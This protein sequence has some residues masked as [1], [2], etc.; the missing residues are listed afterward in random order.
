MDNEEEQ[1]S[2]ALIPID[3]RNMKK[4][5]ERRLEILHY[6]REVVD[7]LYAWAQTPRVIAAPTNLIPSEPIAEPT[8]PALDASIEERIIYHQ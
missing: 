4:D 6:Q 1:E 8:R 2:Q 5:D 3:T 7:V